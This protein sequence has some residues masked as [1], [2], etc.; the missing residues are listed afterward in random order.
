MRDQDYRE[1]H[2]KPGKGE[3]YSKSFVE[4]PFRRYM[5]KWEQEKMNEVFQ[6]YSAESRVL[7][8]ACGTGRIVSHLCSCYKDVVGVDVSDSMLS[9]ESRVDIIIS[10]RRNHNT[11]NKNCS[12]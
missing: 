11:N 2:T 4:H 10:E 1:S 6:I 9:G 8:F 7:D 12:E 3:A 5:S